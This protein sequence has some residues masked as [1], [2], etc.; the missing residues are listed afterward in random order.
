MLPYVTHLPIGL[1][2]GFHVAQYITICF[3][4]VEPPETAAL[5][6]ACRSTLTLDALHSQSACTPLP[7]P[8]YLATGRFKE[9]KT[10]QLWRSIKENPPSY[11]RY[12]GI[13]KQIISPGEIN[14]LSS[15]E[16]SYQDI[17]KL[18]GLPCRKFPSVTAKTMHIFR[19]K[20]SA[21]VNL[22]MA[23]HSKRIPDAFQ[24]QF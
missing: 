9:S 19:G 23:K 4:E 24:S 22:A 15:E 17:T 14:K 11:C 7:E 18:F 5:P 8:P 16:M 21:V 10:E 12:T 6:F 13:P 3:G 2:A 1:L 20:A